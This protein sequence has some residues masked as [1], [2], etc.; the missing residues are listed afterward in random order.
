LYTRENTRNGLIIQ[1]VEKPTELEICH[2]IPV[3]YP[4]QP[5]LKSVNLI[6]FSGIF[7]DFKGR[8]HTRAVT[9]GDDQGGRKLFQGI[10]HLP[11]MANFK[12]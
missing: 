8:Q 9:G 11:S 6:I 2:D 7:T 10:P 4:L 3:G 5:L 12:K 1:A